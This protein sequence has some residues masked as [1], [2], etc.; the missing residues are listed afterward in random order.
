MTSQNPQSILDINDELKLINT[1]IQ[2]NIINLVIKAYENWPINIITKNY[3]KKQ[4]MQNI[5]FV[6]SLSKEYPESM[7]SFL[8]FDHDLIVKVFIVKNWEIINSIILNDHLIS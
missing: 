7:F 2:D 3:L 8:S 1:Y 6:A 4:C 5:A